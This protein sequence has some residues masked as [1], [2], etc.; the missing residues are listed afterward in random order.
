MNEKAVIILSGGI[1]SSTLCYKYAS[2]NFDIYCLTIIYG[3]RH[4][5]EVESA[6]NVANTLGI[7]HRVVDLSPLNQL[8]TGSALTVK[9]RGASPSTSCVT[10]MI[11]ER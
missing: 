8:L 6:K 5:R 9:L 2:D 3:Q 10:A 11:P 1:D 7:S 4:L